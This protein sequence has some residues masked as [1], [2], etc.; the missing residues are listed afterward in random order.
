MASK[1]QAPRDTR[2][3]P[4]ITDGCT[5]VAVVKR[6]L[7]LA[8]LGLGACQSSRSPA[9]VQ[10]T[11][12]GNQELREGDTLELR[13]QPFPEGRPV[14]VTLRGEVR[15]PGEPKRAGVELSLSGTSAST[16]SVTVPITRQVERAITGAERAPHATFHGSIEVSFR[17][18]V[19]G[20]PPVTG[21]LADVVLDFVPAEEDA[22]LASA[23][24]EKGRAFASYAG[25]L[26]ERRG[27]RFAVTGVMP[28]GPAERAGVVAGDELLELDGVRLLELSD[29]VPAAESRISELYLERAGAKTRLYLDVARF[30]PIAAGKLAP[31][32]GI[33]LSLALLFVL[34]SSP[35]GRGLSLL[36]WRLTER[37]RAAQRKVPRFG[38]ASRPSPFLRAAL[39]H[40]PSSVGPYVA[41]VV[42]FAVVTALGFGRTLVARELDLAVVLVAAY[43]A[44]VLGVLLFGAPR[45]RGV[46]ARLRRALLV[47]VQ[48]VVAF[49]AF[50]SVV[51]STGG[52]GAH[53]LALMQGPWP[54]EFSAL[55]GP[56]PLFSFALLAMS[57][58]PDAALG[59]ADPGVPVTLARPRR[60]GV[61]A[62]VAN[63]HLLL[64][65]GAMA[66]AFLGGTRV[67]G[68][69]GGT[70]VS[71]VG[72]ALLLLK[73]VSVAGLVVLVRRLFGPLDL[74]DTRGPLLTRVLP[75]ALVCFGLSLA[76]GRL[77]SDAFRVALERSA[78]GCSVILAVALVLVM[79]RRALASV[80]QRSVEPGLNPWI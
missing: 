6:L 7:F 45:E 53:E 63:T 12:V 49:G 75:S 39:A 68:D 11:G 78:A 37:L 33:V 23:R 54:W 32:A 60:P 56:L 58:V 47:L 22:A 20:T 1:E 9:L 38:H 14:D 27:G 80:R 41:T 5:L 52:L 13:G 62:V 64:V 26:L 25:L 2:N 24:E 30:E 34:L 70:V 36:E 79:A 48:A 57:L 44:L 65:S 50:G 17:P 16:R 42:A 73:T 31:L 77:A 66:L 28:D 74:V 55:R 69:R 59:P 8:L 15:R 10:V 4:G 3:F 72:V 19:A 40:L 46:V 61:A 35:L 51:L 67:V 21:E 29:L 76:L 71:L 18:R 43:A